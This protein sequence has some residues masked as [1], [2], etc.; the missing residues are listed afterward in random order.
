[1]KLHSLRSES[2]LKYIKRFGDTTGGFPGS[3]VARAPHC[4]CR[5]C[6]FDPRSGNQDPACRVAKK[7][8][9]RG[10]GI[11]FLWQQENKTHWL[12][13][14]KFG[15]QLPSLD[16]R[17]EWRGTVKFVRDQDKK[18]KVKEFTKLTVQSFTYSTLTSRILPLTF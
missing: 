8:K 11:F 6:G 2:V 10:L 4:H 18:T 1:M 13:I 14:S 17:E 12:Q 15:I 5:R 16:E 3:P 7:K 9:K